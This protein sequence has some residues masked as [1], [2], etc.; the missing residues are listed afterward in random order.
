MYLKLL[1]NNIFI[2]VRQEKHHPYP[3]SSIIINN[4]LQNRGPMSDGLIREERRSY[5]RKKI[6]PNERYV[7]EYKLRKKL[8][9]KKVVVLIENLSASG[10]LFFSNES[11]QTLAILSGDIEIPALTKKIKLEARV[12]RSGLD[13]RKNIFEIAVEFTKIREKDRELIRVEE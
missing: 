2:N 12:I 9:A 6:S 7:F 4:D 13:K 8:F 5:P 10:F 3:I 1:F 11:I